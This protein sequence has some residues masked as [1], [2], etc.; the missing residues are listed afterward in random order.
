MKIVNTAQ[1]IALTAAL[2]GSIALGHAHSATPAQFD[3]AWTY[4][5]Q[6][7]EQ[8]NEAAVEKAQT[9]FA[10]LLQAEPTNLVLM[11]YSGSTTAMLAT[12]TWL[13][14][15]KMR[16]AEDGLAMLDKSL[17]LITPAHDAPLQHNIPAVLEVKF[18]AAS[19][20]LAV[21][22]FMNRHERGMKLLN[23]VANSPLLAKA[24]ED[25]RNRVTASCKK[26]G[27]KP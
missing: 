13:P 19:T 15:K 20:F 8:H 26:Q 11:A 14:W 9:A 1:R 7:T 16:F 12:T 2:A 22:S 4:F 27:C 25:F 18:V 5:V 17:T 24:P 23:E 3:P 21:P 10:N 6:A